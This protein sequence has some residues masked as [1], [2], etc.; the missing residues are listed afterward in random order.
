[1]TEQLTPEERVN[2]MK[3][4]WLQRGKP[5]QLP[6]NIDYIRHLE[7]IEKNI[8]ETV[9]E[10]REKCAKIADELADGYRGPAAAYF[11]EVAFEIRNRCKSKMG[12]E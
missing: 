1:M 6:W 9:E 12:G 8:R 2:K 4:H 3:M 11:T 7:E 5:N 10:E